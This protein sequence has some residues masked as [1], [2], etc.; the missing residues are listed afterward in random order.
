MNSALSH[1][2][3]K[4]LLSQY[5]LIWLLS[6]I[7][8]VDVLLR[9][10]AYNIVS[11]AEFALTLLILFSVLCCRI[12]NYNKS[13]FVRSIPLHILFIYFTAHLIYSTLFHSVTNINVTVSESFMANILEFRVSL[14]GYFML[15]LYWGISEI[16]ATKIEKLFLTLLKFLSIYT[17]LEQLLSLAGLRTFFESLYKN[18]GIVSDNLVGLKSLGLYR[19]WGLVGSTQLLGLVHIFFFIWLVYSNGSRFWR[20]VALASILLSTSKTAYFVSI[21]ILLIYCFKQNKKLLLVITALLTSV[22]TYVVYS[23]D[24][25][26]NMDVSNFFDSIRGFFLIATSTINP[27]TGTFEQGGAYNKMIADL[28]ANSYLLGKGV[29]YSYDAPEK[30]PHFLT[31]YYYITSDYYIMSFTQQFGLLGL[32]LFCLLFCYL[33]FKNIMSDRD[34]ANNFILLVFFFAAF[35]YSPQISKLIM[36]FVGYALWKVYLSPATVIEKGSCYE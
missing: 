6:I 20:F 14:L 5:R 26:L 29:T 28:G 31:K 23:I 17:I 24:K 1:L 27:E 21:I 4:N 7:L 35:H 12:G 10:V 16:T 18:A 11:V 33:P 30:I 25:I 2:S 13:V 9:I 3:V 19:I 15:F 8:S 22:I 32:F 36:M 34:P